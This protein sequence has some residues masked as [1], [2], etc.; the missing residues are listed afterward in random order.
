MPIVSKRI[1]KIM[2]AAVWLVGGIVLVAKGSALLAEAARVRQSHMWI[3]FAIVVG[4]LA[5]GL[6]SAFIFRSSCRKNLARID[7][8][9]RP[10]IWNF[11]RPGFFLALALMIS[12]GATMS[13]LAHGHYPGLIGVGAL[14][15]ALGTA[16]LSSSLVFRERGTPTKK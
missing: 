9:R 6:K 11:F 4:L 3:V 13:S 15:L 12:A 5:G 8:L 16:L 14:D 1:L 7:A 10:R 2:A